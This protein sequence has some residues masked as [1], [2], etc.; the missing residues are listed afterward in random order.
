VPIIVPTV[1]GGIDQIDFSLYTDESVFSW[2]EAA[3]EATVTGFSGASVASI[4]IPPIRASTGASVVAIAGSAFRYDNTITSVLL[5][6]GLVEIGGLAFA[7]ASSITSFNLPSTL[8]TIGGE[9]LFGHTSIGPLALPDGL[10]TL[11]SGAFSNIGWNGPVNIPDSVVGSYLT[12]FRG[13][14]YTSITMGSGVTGTYD[15]RSTNIQ[16]VA[17]G[18]GITALKNLGKTTL[19]SL[20]FDS[21]SS[22][23]TL[24]NYCFKNATNLLSLTIPA[25]MTT[26]G[27]EVFYGCSSLSTIDFSSANIASI[28]TGGRT[29]QGCAVTSLD[30]SNSTF[31][32]VPFA[33]CFTASSL[34]EI[35]LPS[36]VITCGSSA[37]QNATSLLDVYYAGSEPSVS[38]SNHYAGTPTALTSHAPVGAEAN[39]PSKTGSAP[40]YSWLDRDLVFDYVP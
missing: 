25:S 10:T 28:G 21:V 11:G 13:N 2:T 6:D 27:N 8:T 19:T 40:T 31:T 35:Y 33:M 9:I 4:A 23:T 24:E 26:V 5:P 30:F 29:F 15:C 16:S 17:V 18:S 38:V 14:P 39:W 32:S 22:C 1:P 7:N 34:T 3:G 20:T 12:W 36:T 37:F